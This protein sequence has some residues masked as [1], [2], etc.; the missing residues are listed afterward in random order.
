MPVRRPREDGKDS[1][2]RDDHDEMD[3]DTGT[4]WVHDHH[5]A[6]HSDER[7]RFPEPVLDMTCPVSCHQ[8]PAPL[9]E[10]TT[11]TSRDETATG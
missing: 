8:T 9:R 1:P 10:T 2:A 7:H 11:T 6:D 5:E 3:H 4:A